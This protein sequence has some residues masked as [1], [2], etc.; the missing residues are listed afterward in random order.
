MKSI[1][2]RIASKYTL[3]KRYV[4]RNFSYPRNFLTKR[5]RRGQYGSFVMSNRLR[6]FGYKVSK[7]F[8]EEP[9]AFKTET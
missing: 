8:G 1:T 5:V 6:K 4:K 2:T 7:S 3:G 9:L